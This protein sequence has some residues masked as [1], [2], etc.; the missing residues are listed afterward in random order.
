MNARLLSGLAAPVLA[1]ASGPA[2][3]DPPQHSLATTRL[4]VSACQSEQ[5]TLRGMCIGY[6]GAMVDGVVWLQKD[7]SR[8][9][10][11]CLP[12]DVDIELFRQALLQYVA[13]TPAAMEGHSLE[14]LKASLEARWPCPR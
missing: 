7:G 10:T 14:A 6:L 8:N 2:V 9:R 5:A 13:K 12:Q 1:V 3:A 11:A 4:L